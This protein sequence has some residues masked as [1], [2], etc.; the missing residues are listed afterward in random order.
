[1]DQGGHVVP[2]SLVHEEMHPIGPGALVGPKEKII[3]LISSRLGIESSKK[4]EERL[5]EPWLERFV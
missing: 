5:W 4:L 3:F 1:M 2:V